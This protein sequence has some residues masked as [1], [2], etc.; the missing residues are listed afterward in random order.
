MIDRIDAVQFEFNEM[1]L[2]SHSNMADIER[3]LDGF[4]LL[5]I[6]YDGNLLPLA[7]APL[8]R[9]NIFCYQNIVALRR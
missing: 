4:D 8:Y 6:L 2:F 9:K 1:N 3:L 5:R 7:S